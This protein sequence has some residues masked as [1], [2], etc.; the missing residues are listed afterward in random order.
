LGFR[1][2]GQLESIIPNSSSDSYESLNFFGVA[3]TNV[4]FADDAGTSWISSTIGSAT[5]EGIFDIPSY[6][7][8][9]NAIRVLV[10][11]GIR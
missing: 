4:A 3:A 9:G 6:S 7:E 11:G 2:I 8:E 10:A 5:A 1:L